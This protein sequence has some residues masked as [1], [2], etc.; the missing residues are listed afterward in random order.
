MPP[1]SLHQSRIVNIKTAGACTKLR[2]EE[3]I[4]NQKLASPR[5]IRLNDDGAEGS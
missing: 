1:V 4:P 3:T 5:L 2:E